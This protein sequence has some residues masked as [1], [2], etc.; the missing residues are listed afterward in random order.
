M[1]RTYSNT[2]EEYVF[3]RY[4]FVNTTGAT[5]NDFYSGIFIDWDIDAATFNSNQGGYALDRNLV[6]QFDT[7]GTPYYY[8]IAVLD[9][10]AGY[11]S[12]KDSPLPDARTG[13]F[14]WI[15]TPDTDPIGTPGDFRCW[16]GAGPVNIAPGD[17]AWFT[18]AV[19]A[20]DDLTD[21][22][23]HAY[24]AAVKSGQV[25]WTPPVG[26]DDQPN[27]LPTE[28]ALYQNYPN[29]FNPSTTIKYDLKENA[30][31]VLKVYNVLGQEVRTLV[32]TN[33]TAGFK[34]VVWDGR[35]N[36]GVPVAS[37]VYIYRIQANDFVRNMKMVLLK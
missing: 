22:R 6:Y 2:G 32:N 12:T 1:Q 37:G 34:K 31:V 18:F 28:F 4:G 5:L 7:S 21:I 15:S 13:S 8:G 23:Q 35:D 14:T 29:P 27:R 16:Q 3:I 17:T 20:G 24:D 30:N 11:K 33:Q 19:V 25:G 10:L 26:I 36:N 9:G